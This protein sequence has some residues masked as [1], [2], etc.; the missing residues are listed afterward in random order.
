MVLELGDSCAVRCK[1]SDL[2]FFSGQYNSV[3]GK[4]KKE[5]TGEVLYEI[6]GQWS[7]E[8]YI[9]MAKASNKT[10]FFD[11]KSA[12]IHP[13]EV[14][15]IEE[16]EPME[17]R[18]LWSKVTAAIL[19]DD[20]DTATTEKTIIEDKQREDTRTREADGIEFVPRYFNLV[21]DQYEFTGLRSIDF[22]NKEKGKAQLED[23]IFSPNPTNTT[24]VK[25]TATATASKP[26]PSY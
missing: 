24:E 10:L 4:V 20:M 23:I 6:S 8:I 12:H 25:P 13:K 21:Q 26:S 18:R 15:D 22:Q 7:N 5:S 19:K 1:T 17:S 3:C 9:K 16:Q 14:K 11:V 2:G